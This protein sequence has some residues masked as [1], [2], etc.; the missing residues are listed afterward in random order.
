[1]DIVLGVLVQMLYA[2]KSESPN[3]LV[4]Q[5]DRSSKYVCTRYTERLMDYNDQF[6][7]IFAPIWLC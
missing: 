2:R 5:C 6:R 1:M 7:S 3:A 4:Y